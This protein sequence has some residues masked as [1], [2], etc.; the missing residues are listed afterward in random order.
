V[1]T[2]MRAIT[3]SLS[4]RLR[5]LSQNE[6]AGD[7]V[8]CMYCT[9]GKHELLLSRCLA[10][11]PVSYVDYHRGAACV[12]GTLCMYVLWMSCASPIKFSS[13]CAQS[14]RRCNFCDTIKV[15][16]ALCC[17]LLRTHY[18]VWIVEVCLFRRLIALRCVDTQS[19][20]VDTG[21]PGLCSVSWTIN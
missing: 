21:L 7:D 20:L 12:L 17:F 2:Y 18:S 10:V 8:Q 9:I 4:P 13:L 15:K 1:C 14:Q 11:L 19:L 5:R 16:F 3:W 6:G